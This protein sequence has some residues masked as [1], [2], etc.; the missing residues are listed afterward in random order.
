MAPKFSVCWPR[1][2]FQR[3]RHETVQLLDCV[4]CERKI[5]TGR[6]S[7]QIICKLAS[8]PED[9]CEDIA[10][11]ELFWRHASARLG[12]MSR[13]YRDL[14]QIEGLIMA[15]VPRPLPQAVH[16]GKVEVRA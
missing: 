8:I 10:A 14:D 5:D 16:L 7:M 2:A 15:R 13:L 4:L 1:R 9:K 12:R 6:P 11:Q 3:R